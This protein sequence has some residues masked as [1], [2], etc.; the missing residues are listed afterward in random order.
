LLGGSEW[1]ELGEG[2]VRHVM[3]RHINLGQHD[4]GSAG[5]PHLFDFCEA[6][7]VRGQPWLDDG[8]VISD[9][10]HACE[11]IGLAGKF[12]LQ[13]NAA[14]GKT[15]SQEQLLCDAREIFPQVL[16]A[17]FQNGHNPSIGGICKTF[18]LLA[19]RPI[20]AD[21]PWWN[22]P[23]TLRAAA[24]LLVL[25]P[26]VQTAAI[27]GGIAACSNGFMRHFVNPAVHLMAY[28]TVNPLGRP[29]DVIPAT[30]DADPGYHTGLSIID[31]LACL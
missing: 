26:G 8:R 5:R 13:L 18:D 6:V 3:N 24:Q 1:L 2:L 15:A 31:Y 27:L 20:N 9:P 11:F 17:N 10:G 28:Q 12:L 21:M 29:V 14:G 16:L 22:L 25:C 30:P 7:D 19:R 4:L 23:E